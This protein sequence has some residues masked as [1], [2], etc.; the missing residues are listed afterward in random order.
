MTSRSV[1][2][3]SPPPSFFPFERSPPLPHISRTL[4][5]SS[6]ISRIRT[7]LEIS[8][9]ARRRT[10]IAIR[11]A[12]GIRGGIDEKEEDRSSSSFPCLPA[13]LFFQPILP[14]FRDT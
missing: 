13:C 7:A 8:S 2:S 1:W 12:G 9:S 4:S 10:S 14:D 6:G 5:G 3:S 11:E